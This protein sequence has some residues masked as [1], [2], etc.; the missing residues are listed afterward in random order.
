MESLLFSRFLEACTCTR[1]DA[2]EGLTEDELYGIY[3]SWCVLQDTNPAPAGE[4]WKAMRELGIRRHFVDS[5][6]ICPHLHMTGPAA[7]DYILSSQPDL[8]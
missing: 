1:S 7:V 3:T 8:I 6:F 4:F 5:R 2:D